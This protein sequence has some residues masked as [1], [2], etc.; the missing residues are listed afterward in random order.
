MHV[1]LV[2]V[3]DSQ[4]PAAA[5]RRERGS[6]IWTQVFLSL[7]FAEDPGVA[8]LQLAGYPKA[9]LLGEEASLCS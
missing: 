7:S 8:A 6:F 1:E 3:E 2:R 9:S 4:S 5:Q